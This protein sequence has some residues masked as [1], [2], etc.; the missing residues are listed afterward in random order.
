MASLGN[1]DPRI[2]MPK[3][4]ESLESFTKFHD[5]QIIKTEI[6]AN[7]FQ[8][9]ILM[10]PPSYYFVLSLIPTPFFFFFLFFALQNFY[11]YQLSLLEEEDGTQKEGL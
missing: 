11:N 2:L 4:A 3:I 6:V 10:A 9:D 7:G 1:M 5:F 8:D